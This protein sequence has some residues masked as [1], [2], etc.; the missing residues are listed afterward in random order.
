MHRYDLVFYARLIENLIIHRRKYDFTLIVT[1]HLYKINFVDKFIHEKFDK[2][3]IA[4]VHILNSAKIITKIKFIFSLRKWHKKNLNSN[5]LLIINDKSNVFSRFFLKNSKNVLLIQQIEDIGNDYKFDIPFFIK[6][7]L[8]SL[9]IGS[10]IA[11][12]YIHKF[13]PDVR[14]LKLLNYGKKN[15]FFIAYNVFNSN[16]KNNFQLP[17]LNEKFNKKIVI[18]GSRFFTW[19]VNKDPKDLKLFVNQLSQIYTYIFTKFQNYK[20]YYIPHPFEKEKEYEFINNIFFGRLIKDEKFFSSEHFLYENRDIEYTFSI[21]STS[22]FSSYSMGYSSKVF[23]KML[24]LPS[25]VQL[26]MDDI[27]HGLSDNFFAKSY[28]DLTNKEIIEIKN[29]DFLNKFTYFL[30]KYDI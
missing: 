30:N 11:K 17:S 27:F 1:D 6:D 19:H 20:F 14:G 18:F 2:V 8:K 24:N 21:C 3:L 15:Y 25:D 10:C 16:I 29:K 22:S 9:I 13:T 23:Y 28:S 5:D 7:T 12:Q 26:I 4:P